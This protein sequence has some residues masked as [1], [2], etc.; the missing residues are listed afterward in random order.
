MSNIIVIYQNIYIRQMC[1]SFI[2]VY[3]MVTLGWIESLTLS[4]IHA[5]MIIHQ[6][7]N[8]WWCTHTKKMQENDKNSTSTYQWKIF[9]LVSSPFRTKWKSGEENQWQ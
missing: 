2:L 7:L 1:G 6:A 8:I 9:I 3:K 4:P 5:K